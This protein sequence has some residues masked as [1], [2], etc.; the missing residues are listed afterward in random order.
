MA[1]GAALRIGRGPR[2]IRRMGSFVALRILGAIA[3]KQRALRTERSDRT[4]LLG[5]PGLTSSK[6]ATRNK[7]IASSNKCLTT[8]NKKL[9]ETRMLLVAKGIHQ[10]PRTS[11]Q[12]T[13][14]GADQRT[15]KPYVQFTINLKYDHVHF[16]MLNVH[17]LGC[18]WPIRPN[19]LI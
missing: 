13:K 9:V 3:T 10:H 16:L 17:F 18:L 15:S 7:C 2:Y 8:S 11:K 4:L 19:F 5:A 6:N 14:V 1:G 12:A